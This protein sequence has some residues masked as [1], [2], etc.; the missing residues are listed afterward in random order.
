M[1]GETRIQSIGRLKGGWWAIP[2]L[3]SHSFIGCRS[4][5]VG[6]CRICI[7]L[8]GQCR[9][10]WAILLLTSHFFINCLFSIVDRIFALELE[11]HSSESRGTM[12]YLYC[13]FLM[14]RRG[15]S[16]RRPPP[17][18]KVQGLHYCASPVRVVKEQE[19][20]AG[21]TV[22]YW[23]TRAHKNTGRNSESTVRRGDRDDSG[24]V[25]GSA[26]SAQQGA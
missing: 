11:S 10:R 13:T 23:M 7:L 16:S 8:I 15:V 12:P 4:I 22:F 21:I 5:V 17:F 1:L 14:R 18:M 3:T 25:R 6:L 19:S 24:Q 9:W 20:V 2:L 26:T